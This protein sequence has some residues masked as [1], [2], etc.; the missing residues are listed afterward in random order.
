MERLAALRRRN[1]LTQA[2]L[3]QQLGVSTQAV[4]NWES[5]RA[6][7]RMRYLRQLCEVLGVSIGELL[8]PEEQERLESGDGD[9]EEEAA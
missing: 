3:A 1:L 8:T 6:W 5:G 2:D 7:P 9:D 4:R